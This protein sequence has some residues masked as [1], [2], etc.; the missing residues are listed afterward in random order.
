MLA[1]KKRKHREASPKQTN[2]DFNRS[3]PAKNKT[4]N[5]GAAVAVPTFGHYEMPHS[6][7]ALTVGTNV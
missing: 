5:H 2:A 4:H 6:V 7:C 1:L 3:V